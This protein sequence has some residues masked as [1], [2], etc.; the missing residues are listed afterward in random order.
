MLTAS[1]QVDLLLNEIA[2]LLY[3]CPYE[4]LDP[5]RA[6]A[7][8]NEASCRFTEAQLEAGDNARKAMREDA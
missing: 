6:D 7:C 1:Q 5:K 3:G 4:V 2:Y 8:I